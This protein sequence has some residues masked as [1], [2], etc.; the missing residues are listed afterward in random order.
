VRLVVKTARFVFH[1]KHLSLVLKGTTPAVAVKHVSHVT[2]AKLRVNLPAKAARADAKSV[3]KAASTVSHAKLSSIVQRDT[4]PAKDARPANQHTPKPKRKTVTRMT[5]P[6]LNQETPPKPPM[7]VFNQA[8]RP[9]PVTQHLT[10]ERIKEVV[11]ET[12][13]AFD[14]IPKTQKKKAITIE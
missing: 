12:L 4:I 14:L 13:I 6:N 7:P 8:P 3:A 1:V 9:I 11:V 5:Q 10:E 2:V